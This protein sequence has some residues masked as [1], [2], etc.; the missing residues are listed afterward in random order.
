M[1]RKRPP[2]LMMDSRAAGSIQHF[3]PNLTDLVYLCFSS[4]LLRSELS[5][6]SAAA[7]VAVAAAAATTV[8][9]DLRS[10]LVTDQILFLFTL[11]RFL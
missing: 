1:Q 6:T 9:L 3:N 7:V 5:R 11:D 2:K 8:A 10:C 4:S